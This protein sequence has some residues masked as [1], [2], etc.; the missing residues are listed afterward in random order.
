MDTNEGQVRHV[1]GKSDFL[2][3]IESGIP[4]NKQIWEVTSASLESFSSFFG[5]LSPSTNY[6]FTPNGEGFIYLPV[7]RGDTPF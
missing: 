1:D 7:G 2:V 5:V 6:R 4:T 3:E